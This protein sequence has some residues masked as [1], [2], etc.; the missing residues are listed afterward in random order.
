MFGKDFKCK[1]MQPLWHVTRGCRTFK[2]RVA[3]RRLLRAYTHRE[4]TEGD[5]DIFHALPH[6][7]PLTVKYAPLLHHSSCTLLPVAGCHI[8]SVHNWLTDP[9]VHSSI[10]FSIP[11]VLVQ[12]KC[13]S[14]TDTMFKTHH[15]CLP[16][17]SSH[18]AAPQSPHSHRPSSSLAPPI[19]CISASNEKP[20]LIRW[21]SEIIYPPP[22]PSA[23]ISSPLSPFL[24]HIVVPASYH[25]P[26]ECFLGLALIAPLSISIWLENE[27]AG[28]GSPDSP[29]SEPGALDCRRALAFSLT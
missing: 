7:N 8:E 5:Q 17:W 24:L 9:S 15:L 19:I 27:W 26:A 29:L 22:P 13:S 12:A 3:P 14:W 18:T 21:P 1:I 28:D 10:P 23:A 4:R 20:P 6:F 16:L 25:H 2:E 11:S